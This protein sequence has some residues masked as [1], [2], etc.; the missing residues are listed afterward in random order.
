MKIFSR[1]IFLKRGYKKN[2][3]FFQEIFLKRG[4]KKNMKF[5]PGKF[6]YIA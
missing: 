5:F 3:K 2:I 4:Y 6:F 1:K